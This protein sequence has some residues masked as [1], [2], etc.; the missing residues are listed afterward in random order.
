MFSRRVLGAD[1]VVTSREAKGT[2]KEKPHCV[3]HCFSHVSAGSV[4]PVPQ[5]ADAPAADHAPA[6]P[7]R[8]APSPAARTVVV[9]L[10]AAP[11]RQAQA[12]V[13]APAPWAATGIQGRWR[14]VPWSGSCNGGVA[15]KVA[16]WPSNCGEEGVHGVFPMAVH[17]RR[18]RPDSNGRSSAW[19]G[20]KPPIQRRGFAS[21]RLASRVTDAVANQASEEL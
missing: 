21:R 18:P 6:E 11:A 12:P 13:L 4:A 7:H 5:S 15:A 14:Q 17:R 10:P 9:P 16:A 19:E 2:N 3:R 1:N 20:D 8:A